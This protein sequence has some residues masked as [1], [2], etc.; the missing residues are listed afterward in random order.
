MPLNP[1]GSDVPR[2]SPRAGGGP[3]TGAQPRQ[4]AVP[5]FPDPCNHL[6][7]RHP[8]TPCPHL[9]LHSPCPL[10]ASPA[11]AFPSPSPGGLLRDMPSGFRL[12][13]LKQLNVFSTS[14]SCK[15]RPKRTDIL[16]CL[17]LMPTSSALC[18]RA[19]G[20]N[21]APPPQ[22]GWQG[23]G[24]RPPH[25]RRVQRACCPQG[26]PHT[27]EEHR[28]SRRFTG[29]GTATAPRS[30]CGDAARREAHAGALRPRSSSC[31]VSTW[32]PQ[33]SPG[34]GLWSSN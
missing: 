5:A 26:L 29:P 34:P 32:P 11:P 13:F 33:T 18:T 14:S 25:P 23:W 21:P 3:E 24:Q 9:Q 16:R 15:N 6:A 20:H 28:A 10:E 12:F 31:P 17:I 8:L 1:W 22:A 7:G 30:P 19:C 4:L 27:C 2:R